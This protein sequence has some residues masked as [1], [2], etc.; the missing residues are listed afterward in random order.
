MRFQSRVVLA[1]SVL[2][3]FAAS[4]GVA[5]LMPERAEGTAVPQFAASTEVQ[6][7]PQVEQ[8]PAPVAAPVSGEQIAALVVT[9][10]RDRAAAIIAELEAAKAAE[11][12][13][14]DDDDDDSPGRSR[15][16]GWREL[17]DQIQEACDDG[18]IR[19]Q[20]CRG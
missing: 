18:R 4:S 7:A 1:G 8:P 9:P 6:A 13:A 12:E 16:D 19:G 11:A 5:L 2:G 3:V 20:I 10:A 14:D 17:R 15:A